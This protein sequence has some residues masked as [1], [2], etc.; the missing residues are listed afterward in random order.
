ME[1]ASHAPLQ[2]VLSSLL[3][4]LSAS[5]WRQC[6][7]CAPRQRVMSRLGSAHRTRL[8]RNEHRLEDTDRRGKH[9]GGHEEAASGDADAIRG[10]ADPLCK[11]DA[12]LRFGCDGSCQQSHSTLP[13][14]LSHSRDMSAYS[15]AIFEEEGDEI[16]EEGDM[17]T[18]TAQGDDQQH[19]EPTQRTK[20]P[21]S[22]SN[23]HHPAAG[24]GQASRPMPTL[25]ASSSSMDVA[26]AAS[27]TAAASASLVLPAAATRAAMDVDVMELPSAASKNADAAGSSPD[28]PSHAAAAPGASP[29]PPPAAAAVPSSMFS[30]LGILNNYR[31]RLLSPT[32]DHLF[33]K[34]NLDARSWGLLVRSPLPA[35]EIVASGVEQLLD[36]VG[37][38]LK[39]LNRKTAGPGPGTTTGSGSESGPG[40]GS[41]FVAGTGSKLATILDS[42]AFTEEVN[43]AYRVYSR[44]LSLSQGISRALKPLCSEIEQ[45]L[46]TERGALPFL[47]LKALAP[48]LLA[49]QDADT[50]GVSMLDEMYRKIDLMEVQEVLRSAAD[51][52]GRAGSRAAS[53]SHSGNSSSRSSISL[54]TAA[55]NGPRST[56]TTSR[57]SAVSG[58][59]GIGLGGFVSR[60]RT[61]SRRNSR[62]VM[63][64]ASM[65]A[66]LGGHHRKMSSNGGS[67][68]PPPSPASST[69]DPSNPPTEPPTAAAPMPSHPSSRAPSQG[70]AT[71]FAGALTDA[72]AAAGR[73]TLH[74]RRAPSVEIVATPAEATGPTTNTTPPTATRLS[75]AA[76]ASTVSPPGA[77]L[78]IAPATS[79]AAPASASSSTSSADAGATATAASAYPDPAAFGVAGVDDDDS[80]E[81]LESTLH[82]GDDMFAR[83]LNAAHTHCYPLPPKLR[84]GKKA[85]AAAAAAAAALP[86]LPPADFLLSYL[87]HHTRSFHYLEN[88]LDHYLLCCL[89]QLCAL[90]VTE[91]L[92]KPDLYASVH[93]D[94][95][96]LASHFVRIGLPLMDRLM[97]VDRSFL[98]ENL[99]A[100]SMGGL[101]SGRM[102]SDARQVVRKARLMHGLF[103]S[104]DIFLFPR[105]IAAHARGSGCKALAL[106]TTD[107]SLVATAGFDGVVRIWDTSTTAR[108]TGGAGAS[109]KCL[110]QFVGS[111]SIVSFVAF[112]GAAGDTAIVSAGFDGVIRVWD[113]RT[114]Q[115]IRTLSGHEDS[116]LD[117]DLGGGGPGGKEHKFVASASMDC[118]VRLWSLST[119]KCLRLYVGH[120]HFVK[121]VRFTR[122]ASTII[123]AGLDQRIFVWAVRGTGGAGGGGSSS[124]AA[125][126]SLSASALVGSGGGPRHT[127]FH[128]DPILDLLVLTP[129]H[130]LSA[131]KDRSLRVWD[132]HKG[133]LSELLPNPQGSTA[134]SLALSPD[135][136]FVAAGFFDNTINVYDISPCIAQAA[137]ATA[138]AGAEAEAKEMR[139][140][141][142]AAAAAGGRRGGG[143]VA[144]SR[145]SNVTLG[146]VAASPSALAPVSTSCRLVRQLRVHNEGILCVR[147]QNKRTLLVGTAMGKLQILHIG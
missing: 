134:I 76:S 69:A 60:S 15:G 50:P 62:G 52:D 75:P 11:L 1:R 10:L 103:A 44:S 16:D 30:L 130:V 71:P 34:V 119:G 105:S 74:L 146:P 108:S 77:S 9:K 21:P 90:A 14:T 114:A 23:S 46:D 128:S 36:T 19:G 72:T 41:G 83:L 84:K 2:C 53:A 95:N 100:L 66:K 89:A 129:H 94:A 121:T 42:S 12:S 55:P 57:A 126:A 115:P 96:D 22:S 93:A 91:T 99:M 116:I 137:A 102:F 81:E 135:G 58:G 78:P 118:T 39:R 86:P 35:N 40:S 32:L 25:P 33:A 65:S 124:S 79:G 104:L 117:A 6:C 61:A 56:I 111:K 112:T 144:G 31:M 133:R 3:P 4:S 70:D 136:C 17:V 113:T 18:V 132:L 48:R 8:Q 138:Q 28:S 143:I 122:D 85:A 80:E 54:A 127:F 45:Y 24:S 27:H 43:F 7:G 49:Q 87:L 51:M 147:W 98:A 37:E 120:K 142:D 101:E 59:G 29:S 47:D 123:S 140:Q 67:A 68:V 109:G 139:Q 73:A 106:A 145:A 26:S 97:L 88:L 5:V 141:E 110:A 63:A 125:L 20:Q 38:F 107:P 82:A 92:Q 13:L 131:S 64:A